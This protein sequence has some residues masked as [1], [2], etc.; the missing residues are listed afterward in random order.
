MR[1][2]LRAIALAP[3]CA[4]AMLAANPPH[5]L[6]SLS[7]PVILST[8]A[9]I[10]FAP[11]G[12]PSG[13]Y[14]YELSRN[15]SPQ[16]STTIAVTRRDDRAVIE[17]NEAGHLGAATA[18]VIASFH[19]N[20]LSPATYIAT[21]QAPFPRNV[22]L[23]TTARDRPHVPFDATTTVRY[24]V[25]ADGVRA[26]VDG[27][28]SAYVPPATDLPGQK[29]FPF[30]LDAP[31][32]TAVMLVPAFRKRTNAQDLAWYSLAFPMSATTPAPILGA[33]MRRVGLAP[34]FEKTPKNAI[35][36][37]V[38]GL[39]TIWF[40]ASS[41]MVYEAHFDALNI[42]AR[43]IAY[44]RAAET[45]SLDAPQAL[46]TPAHIASRAISIDSGDNKLLGTLDLPASATGRVPVV[47]LVP[48]GPGGDRNYDDNG[49]QPMFVDVAEAFT[50]RGF[51]VLRYDPRGTG[52]DASEASSITWDDARADAEAAIGFAQ[53]DEAIDQAHIYVMGYGNG[54][55]LALASAGGTSTVDRVAGAVALAPTTTS[56][57]NCARANGAEL[58][59]PTAWQRSAFAHDPTILAQRA[60]VP[61]FVLQPGVGVCGETADAIATYDDALRA[62]NP[63]ATIV[64]ASDLSQTFGGRYDADS[65]ANTQMFFPYRFDTSTLGAIADWL[66]GPH[67]ASAPRGGHA[68]DAPV[69]KQTP[70]PPVERGVPQTGPTA[71]EVEP[72]V[73]SVPSAYLTEPSPS[74]TS[75]PGATPGSGGAPD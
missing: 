2:S 67:D 1:P 50:A 38:A 7:D 71:N 62:A 30:V 11:P 53:G 52:D 48:P 26:T 21:Y 45:A 63:S 10:S 13:T 58:R 57:A 29:H 49:P 42:S 19:Y 66:A 3:L 12:P 8:R 28:S 16:G 23:G 34:Q 33:P 37:S 6:P 32:M 70:P 35:A 17:T 14:T 27:V 47:I 44:A 9:P 68:L 46:A 15:G 25:G 64:V 41:G 20:D 74:P 59:H 5:R 31:F 18:R 39:G 73:L 22:P 54:A 69:R 43:L 40:D 36:I 65:Q 51:A 75:S 60:L 55:D 61:L 24:D 72:G 56:Y 4:F